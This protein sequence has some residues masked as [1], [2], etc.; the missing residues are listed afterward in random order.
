MIYAYILQF[1]ASYLKSQLKL[2]IQGNQSYHYH[3]TAKLNQL[4]NSK[5]KETQD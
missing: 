5:H 3:L 4:N 1:D 2:T